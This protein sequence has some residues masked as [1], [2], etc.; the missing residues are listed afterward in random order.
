MQVNTVNVENEWTLALD[1]QAKTNSLF[2]V[3]MT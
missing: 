1:N 3:R 2:V